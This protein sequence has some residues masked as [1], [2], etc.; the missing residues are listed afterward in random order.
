VNREYRIVYPSGKSYSLGIERHKS[1]KR[2]VRVY[3]REK[4]VVDA[5]K[6][7][8]IDTAH[9]VLREYL[10]KK[11]KDLAKLTRYAKQ[12]K[13]PLDKEISILLSD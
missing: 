8:P 1:G 11:D 3:D 13:K 7:L 9:K 5:F 10:R 6:Y 12:L 4:S 2:K